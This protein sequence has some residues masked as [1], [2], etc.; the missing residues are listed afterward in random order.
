[1][2]LRFTGSMG[3]GFK[4]IL[5][6]IEFGFVSSNASRGFPLLLVG[7]LRCSVDGLSR[8]LLT[9][10]WVVQLFVL[11]FFSM[12][13]FSSM[14]SNSLMTISD[15]DGFLAVKDTTR[16]VSE[17]APLLWFLDIIPKPFAPRR[18]P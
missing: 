15:I 9:R 8:G 17:L 12:V 3:T 7:L 18:T 6:G 4:G 14:R 1:M 10:V 16:T 2:G 13:C 11:L 5:G